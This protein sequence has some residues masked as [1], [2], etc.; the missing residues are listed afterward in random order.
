MENTVL[1]TIPSA[2]AVGN[3]GSC[4]NLFFQF[5]NTMKLRDLLPLIAQ[6]HKIAI[7]TEFYSFLI[8]SED[9]ARL[10]LMSN[11]VDN[12][13]YIVNIGTKKFALHKRV[14]QDNPK[15]Q[16][17]KRRPTIPLGGACMPHGGNVPFFNQA[18]NT[19]YQEWNVIKKNDFGRRQERVLGMDALKIYNH[20]RGEMR[21]QS[22]VRHPHRDITT[23]LNVTSM[24][25][26]SSAFKI[27]F[28]DA[29]VHDIEYT[30][31]SIAEKNEIM[32]KLN[33]IRARNAKAM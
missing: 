17:I 27:H 31:A 7:F 19:A 12:D 28:S 3:L 4:G 24:G 33:F 11:I 6:K 10:K 25:A 2:A 13:T 22:D 8:S 32:T 21:G 9:Q 23:I 20:K 5:T 18:V 26:D 30:C 29:H 15:M 14:F 16:G 1:V